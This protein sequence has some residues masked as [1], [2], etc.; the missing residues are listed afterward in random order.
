[1]SRSALGAW[2]GA[3]AGLFDETPG[4]CG[5]F[6]PA[7]LAEVASTTGAGALAFR[8]KPTA[9]AGARGTPLSCGDLFEDA[10]REDGTRNDGSFG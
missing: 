2:V 10:R 8:A 4:V 6:E 1:M 9:E 3:T 5:G 7:D